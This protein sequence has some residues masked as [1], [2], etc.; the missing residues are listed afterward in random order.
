MLEHLICETYFHLRYLIANYNFH[1]KNALINTLFYCKVNT[2]CYRIVFELPIYYGT[3]I[4]CSLMNTDKQQ[5]ERAML[6]Y[7]YISLYNLVVSTKIKTQTLLT[8]PHAYL[9]LLTT[10]SLPPR[11]K[12]DF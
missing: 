6:V 7:I 8:P 10:F 5:P 11:F 12:K 4:F 3:S 9:A 2:L 1:L